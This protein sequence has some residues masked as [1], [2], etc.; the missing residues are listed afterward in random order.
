MVLRAWLDSNGRD[1]NLKT[2]LKRKP[3]KLKISRQ[4]GP[5]VTTVRHVEQEILRVVEKLGVLFIEG[6]VLGCAV[7]GGA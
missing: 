6:Q 1:G 3:F 7:Y 5:P 2:Y 4:Q